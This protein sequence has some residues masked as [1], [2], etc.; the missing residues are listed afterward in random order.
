MGAPGRA[1]GSEE[2][3]VEEGDAGR[4]NVWVTDDIHRQLKIKAAERRVTL[5]SLVEDYLSRGLEADKKLAVHGGGHG[6]G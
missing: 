4:A 3:T 6:E 5:R 1:E 2:E